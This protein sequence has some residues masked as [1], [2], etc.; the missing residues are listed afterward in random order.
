MIFEGFAK[1]SYGLINIVLGFM[2]VGGC[3][4]PL[5]DMVVEKFGLLIR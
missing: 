1:G 2:I 4:V 5:N 3:P